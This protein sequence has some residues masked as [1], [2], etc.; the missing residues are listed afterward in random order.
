[1][2]CHGNAQHIGADFSFIVGFPVPNPDVPPNPQAA[3][4]EFAT[5][6]FN[7]SYFRHFRNLK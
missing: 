6:R 3:T 7:N 4:T 1:M 2:G 5:D